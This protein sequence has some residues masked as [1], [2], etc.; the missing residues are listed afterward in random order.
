MEGLA[1]RKTLGGSLEEVRARVEAALKEEG[2]G[3]LTEIDVAGVLKA[4]LGLEHPPYRILGA[5]NPGLAARALEAEPDLG[6]LLP[7]N[8]VLRQKAEGVEVLIQDPE[9]MFALLP[10]AVRKR[11]GSLPQEARER[12]ARALARLD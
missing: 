12:L 6:L 11:L 3:I 4:R 7:C 8:V 5:C 2:F 10:E 9:G 1:L